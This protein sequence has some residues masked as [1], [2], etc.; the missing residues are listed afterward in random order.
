M[1]KLLRVNEIFNSISGEVCSFGQGRRT[2][3][4]RMS[5][6]NLS[7]DYCDTPGTQNSDNGIWMSA[8]EIINE[9]R[10]LACKYI[11]ITGGEPLLQFY[12]EEI[13][14]ELIDNNY[15]INIETNGTINPDISLHCAPYTNWIVDYKLQ[16]KDRMKFNYEL[17]ESNDYIKFVIENPLQ[18]MKAVNKQIEMQLHIFD[19]K[20]SKP[21]F[22]YSLVQGKKCSVSPDELLHVLQQNNL[23]AIINVQ[24][25]KLLKLQ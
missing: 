15:S 19:M 6:C 10:K 3:F 1:T 23:D 20:L 21:N 9:V 14:N 11:I 4:I 18:L 24:I 17:L 2:T 8:E 25:H 22:C 7:C 13:I 12:I 5:G 16:Y